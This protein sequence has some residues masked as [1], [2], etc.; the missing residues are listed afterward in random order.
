MIMGSENFEDF[1][2]K[3]ADFGI[4]VDYDPDHKIDLKFMLTKQ[5]E[6]Y[7]SDQAFSSLP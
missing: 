2:K 1:L 4:F 5:K 6:C 3:C 7:F